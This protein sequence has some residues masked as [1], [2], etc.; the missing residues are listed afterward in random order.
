MIV[1]SLLT[2]TL[3][4]ITSCSALAEDSKKESPMSHHGSGSFEVKLTPQSTQDAAVGRMSIAKTFHGAIEGISEGEML[5]VA[6]SVK[7]S[8]GY[9]AIEKVSGSLDGKKG[10]FVL[11]HTATMDRGT[12][13]LS[14]SVVPDSGTG[15]LRG[16][17]GSMTIDISNGTHSYGFDYAIEPK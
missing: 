7:G 6:T 2:L 11:Q 12:P 15:D 17:S 3:V 1:R 16:L 10:S 8:A 13:H 9:V 5:M 4:A 14:I